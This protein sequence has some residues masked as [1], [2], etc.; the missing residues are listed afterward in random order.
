MK[1]VKKNEYN[2]YGVLAKQTFR[3]N[4]FF[5]GIARYFLGLSHKFKFEQFKIVFGERE[6]DIYISTYPKSGTT[7]MQMI[8]YHLTTDGKMNFKHI[9]DVSPW[10][11]NASFTGQKPPDLSSPRIIKTHDNYKDFSK[12]TKG[13]FIYIY[14][15]GM[16]VA[17]SN[18]HQQKNYNN[19]ELKLDKYLTI[20]FKQKKWFKHTREWMLNKKNLSILY[21]KYED[22][23]QNKLKEIERIISFL[24]I[25]RNKKAINRALKYSSFEFMKKNESLFGE[26]PKVSKKTYNQFIRK[27]K[28]GD[29]KS[30]LTK[31]QKG[32][33]TK[34]YNSLVK[35]LEEKTFSQK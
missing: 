8:L 31:K 34:Y 23:L 3:I 2:G 22:L 1:K 5:T 25:P 9:Y 4:K 33:F 7:L 13:K 28:S 24:G 11:H 26:Q 32:I 18:Y 14:R 15:N 29:G 27:G 19:S 20:F 16:D 10:I 17:V 6:D 35:N 30:I 21:V 12:K